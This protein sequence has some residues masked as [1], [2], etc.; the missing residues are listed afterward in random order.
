LMQGF[1]SSVNLVHLVQEVN[2]FWKRKIGA[3]C[4][5]V[6][7]KKKFVYWYKCWLGVQSL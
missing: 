2:R 4:V 1:C 6:K 3:T 7:K 5:F